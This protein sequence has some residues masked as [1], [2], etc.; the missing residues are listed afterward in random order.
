MDRKEWVRKIIESELDPT[1]KDLFKLV[2]IE[3][4][5]SEFVFRMPIGVV[6]LESIWQ[7]I[8]EL[9]EVK[10]FVAKQAPVFATLDEL[11]D[12]VGNVTWLW[13]KWIPKG[14]ITM[15]AGDPGVGKTTEAI[16]FMRIITTGDWWPMRQ[17]RAMK[18]KVVWVDA[19]AGQ[20]ILRE[21]SIS[22][23]VDRSKVY[24]P[25][26]EGDIL[27]SPDFS[28][29]DHRDQIVKLV[30]GVKPEMLV[31]DSLGGS[32]RG[33][34]NR[35]EEVRPLLEFLANLSRDKNI[36]VLLLHHL[37]KGREGESTEVS[38]Y[39]IRGSTGITAYCRSIIAIEKGKSEEEKKLRVIKSNLAVIHISDTIS[40]TVEVDPKDEESI[41]KIVY[42]EYKA[43][44]EKTT[45]RERCADWI[46]ELLT[47]RNEKVALTE[48]KELGESLGFSPNMLYSA[49]RLLGE[50]IAVSGGGNRVFWQL[51]TKLESD[52]ESME[53][54]AEAK[55]GK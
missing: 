33:G 37:N 32:N 10:N 30:E 28:R 26:I 15:L 45:K 8:L 41:K 43:P 31:V 17:E 21:R 5:K 51:S 44:P 55:N 46:I 16:D 50:Q 24:I 29:K 18:G 1:Q 49:R 54:I 7:T 40:M 12:V 27:G 11:D 20:Q 2:S 13:K 6:S 14:F 38:L 47:E 35:I 19:E 52:H 42:G 9:S 34:E 22:L 23:G 53:K 39:R 4:R 36:A 25:V 48:L 3:Q